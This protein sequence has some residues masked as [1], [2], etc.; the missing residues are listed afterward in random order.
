M[1]ASE[2][3][4]KPLVATKTLLQLHFACCVSNAKWLLGSSCERYVLV[5]GNNGGLRT[6]ARAQGLH[7]CLLQLAVQLHKYPAIACGCI[8]T[9]ICIHSQECTRHQPKGYDANAV[10]CVRWERASIEQVLSGA[11]R[12]LIRSFLANGTAPVLTMSA[13]AQHA[14][15]LESSKVRRAQRASSL[16]QRR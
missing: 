5:H 4:I 14:I 16:L 10:R 6:A 11:D 8:D 1:K 13:P 7:L 12:S 15:R 2:D 9:N 3:V